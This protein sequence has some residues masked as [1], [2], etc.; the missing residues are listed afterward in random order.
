MEKRAIPTFRL[1][2][3]SAALDAPLNG[4]EELAFTSGNVKVAEIPNRS[5]KHTIG[6]AG[7]VQAHPKLLDV[8]NGDPSYS[9]GVRARCQISEPSFGNILSMRD[10]ESGRWFSLSAVLE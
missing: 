6:T 3:T 8:P 4:D 5:S 10:A 9:V 1:S 7:N 2:D